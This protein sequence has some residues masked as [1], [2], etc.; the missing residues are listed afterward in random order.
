MGVLL[1][2]VA[3][4]LSGAEMRGL[5]VFGHEAHSLQLCGDTRVFWVRAPGPLYQ[6]LQADYWRLAKRPYEPLY[7]EIEGEFSEH[8]TSG[9]AA[10]YDGT[11]VVSKV[12]RI[13]AG[14]IGACEAAQLR[15]N[16]EP[17]AGD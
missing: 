8:S 10:D 6:R 12:R 1:L 13:S 9:F 7:I 5:L 17:V 16:V 3:G 11:I 14:G 4:S 15:P 2:S